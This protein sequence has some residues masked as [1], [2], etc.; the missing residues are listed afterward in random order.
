MSI[1]FGAFFL[2][3]SLCPGGRRGLAGRGGGRSAPPLRAL[4]PPAL[5]PSPA[6]QIN[7]LSPSFLWCLCWSRLQAL[8]GWH[9]CPVSSVPLGLGRV[10]RAVLSGLVRPGAGLVP[11]SREPAL[12]TAGDGWAGSERCSPAASFSLISLGGSPPASIAT[13]RQLLPCVGLRC[14]AAHGHLSPKYPCGVGRGCS[15]CRE[16]GLGPGRWALPEG[17]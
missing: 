9:P 13:P 2:I 3:S 14:G 4:A 1:R 8:W 10:P 7:C 11:P 15:R 17:G 12:P 5:P 16:G 6:R